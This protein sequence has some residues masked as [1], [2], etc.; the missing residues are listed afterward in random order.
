MNIKDP[1]IYSGI[2]DPRDILIECHIN[3]LSDMEKEHFIFSVFHN[4][5]NNIHSEKYLLPSQSLLQYTQKF[6][7]NSTSVLISQGEIPY[8][9]ELSQQFTEKSQYNHLPLEIL[10]IVAQNAPEQSLSTLFSESFIGFIFNSL[11]HIK[12]NLSLLI[13]Y[14]AV[15][16]S[17]LRLIYT[18]LNRSSSFASFFISHNS[19]PSL[20]NIIITSAQLI[21]EDTL[22]M[23]NKSKL[24]EPFFNSLHNSP[25]LLYPKFDEFQIQ[26]PDEKRTI[27]TP[28]KSTKIGKKKKKLKKQTGIIP[29][30]SQPKNSLNKE[31]TI[32]K[33]YENYNSDQIYE[34]KWKEIEEENNTQ[35][36]AS[37]IAL[38]T[39]VSFLRLSLGCFQIIVEKIPEAWLI[40][41]N[42]IFTTIGSLLQVQYENIPYGII[43]NLLINGINSPVRDLTISFIQNPEIIKNICFL[44]RLADETIGLP[45]VQLLEEI[46]LNQPGLI[47]DN[48]DEILKSLQNHLV[49]RKSE[50]GIELV[51]TALRCVG[52]MGQGSNGALHLFSER[53]HYQIAQ[54]LCNSP[55]KITEAAVI[56]LSQMMHYMTPEEVKIFVETYPIISKVTPLIDS[57]SAVIPALEVLNVI[58]ECLNE[59]DPNGNSMKSLKEEVDIEQLKNFINDSQDLSSFAKT[60]LMSLSN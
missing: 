43:I 5:V 56:A 39:Q 16:L 60:L 49:V 32:N 54:L 18:L 30:A 36:D 4:L 33:T 48:A 37:M 22:V 8:L 47:H 21:I 23:D 31:T 58:A 1:E 14:N 28:K 26:T 7:L 29:K 15:V 27:T 17:S 11:A 38:N 52:I 50:F 6:P 51:A 41:P 46:L 2:I 25:I 24:I 10:I 55:F 59:I 34:M 57:D 40:F 19:F 42:D 35:I 45:T 12:D 9:E 53:I 3:D 44:L 20:L 13:P